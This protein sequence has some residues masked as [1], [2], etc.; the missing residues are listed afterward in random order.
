MILALTKFR[1]PLPVTALTRTVF[2]IT[3]R[4]VI[5][6]DPSSK[7]DTHL[8]NGGQQMPCFVLVGF[9]PIFHTPRVVMLLQSVAVLTENFKAIKFSPKRNQK[10]K[11]CLLL[12]SEIPRSGR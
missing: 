5:R 4:S 10:I 2:K 9:I 1:L 3:I 6:E 11:A 8:H 12:F 7:R